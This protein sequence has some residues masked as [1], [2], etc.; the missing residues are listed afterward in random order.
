MYLVA[1]NEED[2]GN[3]EPSTIRGL[4]LVED[5]QLQI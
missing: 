4:A 1:T 5:S 2:F 3:K